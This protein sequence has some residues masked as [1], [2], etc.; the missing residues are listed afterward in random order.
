MI[1][2]IIFDWIGTLFVRYRDDV[3][4]ELFHKKTRT[5]LGDNI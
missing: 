5:E 4:F 2:G 3:L 1:E